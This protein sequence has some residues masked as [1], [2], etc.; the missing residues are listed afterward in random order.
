MLSCVLEYVGVICLLYSPASGSRGLLSR[1]SFLCWRQSLLRPQVAIRKELI[2]FAKP[3][4]VTFSS[5]NLLLQTQA[6]L[7]ALNYLTTIIPSDG[8]NTGVVKEAQAAAEKQKNS[9]LQKGMWVISVLYDR[10]L[11]KSKLKEQRYLFCLL[12]GD[13]NPQGL[14]AVASEPVC[15]QAEHDGEAYGRDCGG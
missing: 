14:G 2:F 15:C 8:E 10:H 12:F 11:E 3:F 1:S 13:V 9:P 5:L 6:L 4:Q 7:S